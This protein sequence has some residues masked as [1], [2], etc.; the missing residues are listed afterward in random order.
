MNMA[1]MK[2]TVALILA[3][4]L[5]SLSAPKYLAANDKLLIGLIPEENIFKQ[6]EKHR[7]LEKYL[8]EKLN[9]KVKFIILSKYGDI[10]DRFTSR[11]LDGAFFGIFTA[12]LA[13]E[14]LGVVPLARPV[15]LDGSTTAEGYI[16]VRNDSGIKTVNDLRGKRAV[17]VD[18]AT[19]TGYIFTVAYL[20]ERGIKNISGYF[21][22]YYFA[23]SQDSVVY[24][25][26]DGRADVGTVK[27]RIFKK[28]LD[29]D[30]TIKDELRILAKS[31]S[32]PD[33]TL[34]LKKD[35]DPDTRQKIKEALLNMH[36]D[37]RGKDVLRELEAARFKEA[38]MEDFKPVVKLLDNAGVNLK[39]YNYR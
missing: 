34:C 29:K 32:L 30:P 37:P 1:I 27:S 35:I 19:A 23:G 31:M 16:I 39:T 9:M 11:E 3:L 7:P 17:F 5:I 2:N 10:I 14:K 33:T 21:R 36:T 8:S 13:H 25:V 38:G 28:L 18:K 20:R 15:G 22:E 26:L 24:A 6:V 12:A 4:V